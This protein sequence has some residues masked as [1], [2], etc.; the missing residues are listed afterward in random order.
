MLAEV[1]QVHRTAMGS[2]WTVVAPHP[3]ATAREAPGSFREHDIHPL[4]GGMI[5]V[6]LP[7]VPAEMASRVDYVDAL[8]PSGAAFSE[9]LAALRC[10][11]D[12]TWAVPI[13]CS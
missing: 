12:S 8:D 1:R 11:F 2:A 7:F 10:R 5:P 3:G 6:S 4:P 13:R 9:A